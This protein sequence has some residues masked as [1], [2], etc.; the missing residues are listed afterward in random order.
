LKKSRRRNP[1]IISSLE[2]KELPMRKKGR[3]LIWRL[4]ILKKHKLRNSWSIR[5][6]GSKSKNKSFQKP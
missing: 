6:I 1:G 5:N 4:N 3:I 2:E